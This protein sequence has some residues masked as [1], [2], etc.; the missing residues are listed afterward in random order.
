MKLR[1][2]FNSLLGAALLTAAPV[3]VPAQAT[4][5]DSMLF[6]RA[7][8]MFAEGDGAAGRAIVDSALV[9]IPVSSPRYAEGLFWRA[10]LAR[11]ALDAER[12]YRRIAVE[13]SL[14]PRVPDALIRLA[15][16]ELARGDRMLAARHLE[17]LLREFPPPPARAAAW[18]WL[19]RVGFEDN[20]LARGCIA[21]DSARALAAADNAELANQIRYESGRCLTRTDS[22]PPAVSL[23]TAVSDPAAGP[24][25]YV[26]V[27]KAVYTVQVGAYPTRAAAERLRTQLAKQGFAAR[28]VPGTKVFR[29]RVGRFSAKSDAQRTAISLKAARLEAWIVNAEPAG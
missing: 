16:L 9:V 11:A 6:A 28:I 22:R 5:G 2:T 7:Q 24:V 3:L 14:S 1:S 26:A 13:Y 12:D 10:S 4:P 20:D 8:R 27:P 21:L 23:P 29:V 17:R 18:Y 25:K 15:Q 19:A